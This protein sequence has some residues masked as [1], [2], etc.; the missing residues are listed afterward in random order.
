MPNEQEFVVRQTSIELQNDLDKIERLSEIRSLETGLTLSPAGELSV[1]ITGGVTDVKV[2]NVSVVTNTVANI[3][4][5]I[6]TDGGSGAFEIA[7]QDGN[8]ALQITSEGHLK[9]KEFD[10]SNL[11][12]NLD[13]Q[14]V[15]TLP[16]PSESTPKGVYNLSNHRLYILVVDV[17]GILDVNTLDNFILG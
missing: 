13:F 7:D 11:S 2:D 15:S 10:S 3:S 4:M 5:P 1:S 12:P 16:T 17:G 8:V 14:V 9:T 6:K